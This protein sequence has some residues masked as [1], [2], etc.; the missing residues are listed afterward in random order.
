[1]G[2]KQSIKNEERSS[3]D[4]DSGLSY[5]QIQAIQRAWR[6]MSKA[7]QASCGRVIFQ[8]Y[9][10]IDKLSTYREKPI[11][12]GILKH[13]EEIV[14][15]LNYIIKNLNNLELI[16]EKCQDLG[17]SHRTMKQYGMKEE[18]WDILG[19]AISE[20]ICENYAWKK[21]RQLLKASNILTNFIIDRIRS[22]FVQKEVK[23]TKLPIKCLTPENKLKH[24]C[25]K[26]C[27][28]IGNG[29]FCLKKIIHSPIRTK[30]SV[31]HNIIRAKSVDN[32]ENPKRRILPSIPHIETKKIEQ[33][34]YTHNFQR[35][36]SSKIIQYNKST[37]LNRSRPCIC[38]FTN[39]DYDLEGNIIMCKEKFQKKFM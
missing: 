3:S 20:T 29:E 33:E 28:T 32:N 8:R 5:Y 26:R 10:T 22:G 12:W 35:R 15:F 37:I 14:C 34:D 36:I 21:N 7:G 27:N 1:M 19:E 17:K 31:N 18:H 16:E 6:H 38:N 11:E 39:I 24:L 4:D 2:N 13:G 9:A 23:I 25:M 30:Y